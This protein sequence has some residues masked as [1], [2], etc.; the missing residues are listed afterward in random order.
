MSFQRLMVRALEGCEGFT[1]AYIDDIVVSSS[2]W[3]KLLDHIQQMLRA[4]NPARLRAN[5]QKS[6][7]GFQELK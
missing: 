2:S 7:L 6:Q 4:L 5:P 1:R 3:P